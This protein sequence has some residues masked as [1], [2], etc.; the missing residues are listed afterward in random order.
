VL[1]SRKEGAHSLGIGIESKKLVI[2][3]TSH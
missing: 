1:L 3:K 2:N